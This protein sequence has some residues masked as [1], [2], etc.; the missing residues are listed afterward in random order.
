MKKNFVFLSVFLLGF[1]ILSIVTLT[2]QRSAYAA[3]VDPTTK[4]T[5]PCPNNNPGKSDYSK[6]NQATDVLQRT[7][8]RLLQQRLN[9]KI[10][11]WWFHKLHAQTQYL[12]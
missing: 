10:P 6:K 1:V 12:R 5:I 11:A 7:Q 9:L 8:P 3:C 4:K 2:P